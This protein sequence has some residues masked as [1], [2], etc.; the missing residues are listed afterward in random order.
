MPFRSLLF[1]PA[2]RLDRLEKALGSGADW[3]ALDL[4]DGVGPADKS[5]ARQALTEFASAG[6]GDVAHRTG[7]RINAPNQPDG[8]RDLA[9]MFDWPVWP[10]MLILPKVEAASQV[11]QIVSLTEGR[12][13][14]F[15]LTLE[16]AAGI[17]NAVEIA[18]AAPEGALLGYGSADHMAETGGTIT[19]PSLAYGRGAV[20]NAAAVAGVP[21][22]DGVWLNY[23][24]LDGL[25]E[26]AELVKSLGFAGKIAIH[27]DQIGP[28]NAIFSPT[29]D[30]IT[31]A[32]ALIAASDAAG[33]GAFAYNGKMVDAPVLA[34]A[35]RIMDISRSNR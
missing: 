13:C 22:M 21:A 4:E 15:L 28:I 14:I 3:V 8:V 31:T 30:E 33:G 35:R 11:L 18:C 5:A 12:T 19:E 24:D 7:V 29:E 27:P 20:V 16:T 2:T 6:L 1:T 34:R 17:A 25:R 10:G 32:R 9:A 23:K 26:E